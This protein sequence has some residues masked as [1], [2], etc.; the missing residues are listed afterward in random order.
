MNHLILGSGNLGIDLGTW[1]RTIGHKVIKTTRNGGDESNTWNYPKDGMDRLW[2]IVEENKI[3]IIWNCIGCGSVELGE[4]HFTSQFMMSVGLTERLL[5]TFTEQNVIC[6]DSN[7]SN[8]PI[9]KYG[10]NKKFQRQLVEHHWKKNKF[11]CFNIM[12]ESL[13]GTYYPEKCLPLKIVANAIKH[14][15]IGCHYNHICPTPTDWLGEQ[16]AKGLDAILKNENPNIRIKP[17]GSVSTSEFARTVLD[18]AGMIEIPVNE[19]G[20]DKWR[21]EVTEQEG[22]HPLLLSRDTATW[23][24][25]L[26]E[27]RSYY[28]D[29]FLNVRQVSAPYQQDQASQ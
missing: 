27:R 29:L 1:L 28:K 21:P 3:D 5:S 6:F 16:L 2:P 23:Q 8:R 13:Y 7:Y 26:M 10:L 19:M 22:F 14:E 17:R 18:M 4:E 15:K 25:L 24:E 12:I 11:K 9:S 20:K